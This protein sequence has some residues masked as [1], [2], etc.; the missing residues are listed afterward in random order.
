MHKFKA[1]LEIIGINPFVFVPDK[2]LRKVFKQ[3]GKDKGHI[4]IHG[5]INGKPYKQTLLKY[6]GHWRLYVNTS[7]LKKSPQRIGEI[8]E[9]TVEF[10]ISD[11][12]ILPHPKLIVALKE[13]KDA[14]KIFE[15]LPPS[16]QKEIIRYISSLKTEKSINKNIKRAINFLNG[17]ERFVGRQK[18]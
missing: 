16:R 17:K 2:I 3:A 9:I 13:N 11:R 8:L 10:D 14:K 6:S 5:L 15:N 1:G 18:P 12:S 7:M 4:P